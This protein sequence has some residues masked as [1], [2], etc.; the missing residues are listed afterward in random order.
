MPVV[1]RGAR[2]YNRREGRADRGLPPHAARLRRPA[3]GRPPATPRRRLCE[4]KVNSL[5]FLLLLGYALGSVPFSYLIAR[6]YGVDVRQVGTGSASP[7][8]VW[9]CVGPLPGALA[10]AADIAKGL[11]PLLL[12]RALT[13]EDLG[14]LLVGLATM[15]GHNWPVFLAFD[16]GRGVS[17]GLITLLCVSYQWLGLT[18]L[19]L[20]AVTIGLRDSAPGIFI[21]FL[22][23]PIF[24]A[25]LGLSEAVV[26]A[27][28]GIPALTFLRRL[29]APSPAGMPPADRRQVFWNRLLFDRPERSHRP[30]R[31]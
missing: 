26:V 7:G 4:L 2:P 23:V 24:A 8:N 22:L 14:V 13:G 17:L 16:G 27:S 6:R 9:R 5:P 21:A 3:D 29:T 15:A 28:T 30:H 25:L 12:A 10:I 20:A 18:L 19:P 11:V 31:C 1:G